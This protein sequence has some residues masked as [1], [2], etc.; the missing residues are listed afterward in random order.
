[1]VHLVKFDYLTLYW[2][3]RYFIIG[4]R[5]GGREKIQKKDI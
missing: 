3:R 5:F 2:T 1:M 4:E